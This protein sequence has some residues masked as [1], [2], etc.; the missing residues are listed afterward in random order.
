[1]PAVRIRWSTRL[2]WQLFR[3]LERAS[4]LRGNS[5]A[6]QAQMTPPEAPTA[7]LWVFVST[8]GELNA[9]DPF[10][11]ELATRLSHLKLVL[12]T[13]RPHYRASYLDRYPNAEVCVTLGHGDDARALARNYPAKLLVVAEIP[14]LPSD[15]PCRF[16]FAFLLEA[17]RRGA[18]ALL[19]NGWLYHYAPTCRMDAI[20]RSLFQRDYLRAFDFICVQTPDTQSQL[21]EA[22]APSERV[23]VTGNI[24]FDAMRRAEWS[25]AQARSPQLLGALIDSARPVIVAGCVT[26]FAE[27]QM[28]LDAFAAVRARYPDAL[29]V[30]APRHPEVRERMQSLHE[31]LTQRAL[32][33]VFRSAIDDA[34]LHDE[35][36]CLVLD[37]MGDLRDFYAAATVAHVGADHNV[38]E[39]LG[40]GKP[41]TVAP[42][43]ESTYPSY[44]VYRMLFDQS[45]LLEATD[46]AQLQTH[47]SHAIDARSGG[48]AHFMQTQAVLERARGAVARHFEV[49]DSCLA[50]V[51]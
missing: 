40:F 13:D 24:K 28:V 10:L 35:I 44:P 16:S 36:A 50:G 47:W 34:P 51:A 31:F 17:K 32:A 11:Q 29:L 7:A 12:I 23:A 4:D 38:L 15:A 37:T 33:A 46:A 3:L 26:N 19:V 21:I 42:G 49:I 41:V 30:L 1:M 45:A 6:S 9:I 5:A 27:Q 43:W 39:P 18:P 2:K 48:G 14:C 20:E 25:P 8:I 22:G